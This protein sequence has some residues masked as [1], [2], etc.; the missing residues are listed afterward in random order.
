MVPL[1]NTAVLALFVSRNRNRSLCPLTLYAPMTY[2]KCF[3]YDSPE[4]CFH[5]YHCWIQQRP[6]KVWQGAYLFRR[7]KDPAQQQMAN[8]VVYTILNSTVEE[9][10]R[11]LGRSNIWN[12]KTVPKLNKT[13]FFRSPL[14]YIA[15][16][17]NAHNIKFT[18]NRLIDFWRIMDNL[19]LW[20]LSRNDG[21]GKSRWHGTFRAGLLWVTCVSMLKCLIEKCKNIIM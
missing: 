15:I 5:C 16:Y 6:P 17:G 1:L 19:K 7:S 21:E 4:Q 14:Y 20:G 2:D 13:N 9:V 10:N 8:N 3:W 12:G 18:H 11:R